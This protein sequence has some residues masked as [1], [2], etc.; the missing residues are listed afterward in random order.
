MASDDRSGVGATGNG[1]VPRE[2]EGGP[3]PAESPS[4]EDKRAAVEQV[5]RSAHFERA[6][7]LRSFLR[8]VC[9]M[10]LA[11]RGPELN[12]HLIGVEALGRPPAYST[13]DDSSVRRCAHTLR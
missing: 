5:L 11:G 12:E 1:V 8:Y 6:D 9:D 10:E 13:T 2:P 3:G 4:A 7:Q